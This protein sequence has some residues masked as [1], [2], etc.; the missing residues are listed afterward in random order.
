MVCNL[1]RSVNR[2]AAIT[3]VKM[4]LKFKTLLLRFVILEH[5]EQ[6]KIFIQNIYE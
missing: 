6:M 1:L 3:F 5:N 2:Y 4:S